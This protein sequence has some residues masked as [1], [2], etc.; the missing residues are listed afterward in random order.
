MPIREC[1]PSLLNHGGVVVSVLTGVDVQ[2]NVVGYLPSRYVFDTAVEEGDGLGGSREL[3]EER[4]RKKDG[5]GRRRR[6]EEGGGGRFLGLMS[7]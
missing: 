3:E 1:L 7:K 6:E 5:E 2:M 4:G